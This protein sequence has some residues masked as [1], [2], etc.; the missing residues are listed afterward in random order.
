MVR[1]HRLFPAA[2][3]LLAATS[4]VQGSRAT[5]APDPVV[6]KVGDRVYTASQLRKSL[7]GV[8]KFELKALAG[9]DKEILRK[10]VDEAF[11]RDELLAAAARLRHA[12]DDRAIQLQL[13]KALAGAVAQR[14]VAS[15]GKLDAVPDDE[16]KAYYDAHAAEYRTP[17]RVRI[18][19]LVVA[20]EGEAKAA[21]VKALADKT[22]EAWPKL[23]TEVSLDPNTKH[24]AGDLG[25]VTVDG[26]SRDPKV[27]VPSEV[28]KAAF[29]LK[30]G[31]IAPAPVKSI[32]GWH[33]V[34]RR[35]SAPASVQS[36]AD[37]APTIRAAL[38][39]KKRKDAYEGLIAKARAATPV[40]VHEELLGE[41]KL[42]VGPRAVPKV[43]P[44]TPPSAPTK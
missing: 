14:E 11:V 40:E 33:V 15:V 9:T 7:D 18:W 13:R 17:E 21:L 30:D 42:D 32:A 37:V 24:R 4:F 3:V 20:T 39:E 26:S 25:F 2:L 12:E 27:K 34:W 19:H 28:A 1:T 31:D 44:S 23:V 5:D 36:V 29:E 35:G 43:M 38:W 8:P 41:V 6:A 16:V 22:R 10:Y